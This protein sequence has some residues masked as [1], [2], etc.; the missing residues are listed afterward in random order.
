MVDKKATAWVNYA[1]A[2]GIVLVVYGHVVKGA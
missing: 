1:K 2:I